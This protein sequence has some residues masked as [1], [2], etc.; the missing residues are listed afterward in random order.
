MK[1]NI[2]N[3][4]YILSQQLFSAPRFPELDLFSICSARAHGFLYHKF[5]CYSLGLYKQSKHPLEKSFAN[6]LP[7]PYKPSHFVCFE[8]CFSQCFGFFFFLFL[9]EET[10]NIRSCLRFPQKL[11]CW[12]PLPFFS[13]G[14]NHLLKVLASPH[15]TSLNIFVLWIFF[16]STMCW[17]KTETKMHEVTNIQAKHGF[18]Q[19]YYDIL[20]CNPQFKGTKH[21][22]YFFFSDHP[23]AVSWR[24][25]GTI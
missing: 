22:F 21:M 5:I 23:W 16:S 15:L 20:I 10:V 8:L 1:T 12:R 19:W 11:W 9:L 4:P 3:A 6:L 17:E 14:W 18:V 24:F 25:H 13:S 7:V 2:S